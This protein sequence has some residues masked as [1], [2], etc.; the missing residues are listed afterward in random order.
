M[1]DFDSISEHLCRLNV[2][3][4]AA[5]VA[6][7][8][9]KNRLDEHALS[10]VGSFVAAMVEKAMETLA[11]LSRLPQKAPKLFSNFDMSRLPDD[12]RAS[13]KSLMTLS[14]IPACRNIIMVGPTGTGKTHLAQTIGNKCCDMGMSVR[15]FK[16]EE[17]SSKLRDLVG[18]GAN[19]KLFS[20]LSNVQCLIID[21]VGYCTSLGPDE[22]ALLFQILDRRYESGKRTTV[23]TSNK[24]PSDW[25]DLFSDSDLAKCV[26]DRIMDR[27][28][29]I[30]I[31]G[32]SYRGAGRRSF[33][34][35]CNNIPVIL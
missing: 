33:K 30:E 17:I 15:Y 18:K 10:T 22:S 13:V 26:L 23:F 14:F 35:N 16:M 3:F 1:M 11:R 27:C 8:A 19:T 34:L 24:M 28:I 6:A 20:D 25:R 2:S 12:S 21:E 5:D 9:V 32:S 4:T 31:R 29:A 7:W